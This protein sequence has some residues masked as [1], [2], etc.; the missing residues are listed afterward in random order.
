MNS[1]EVAARLRR[2]QGPGGRYFLL[3]MDHGLPAGPL[4]G[5]EDPVGLV[6]RI[7]GAPVTA[8]IAN[9][10][11]VSRLAPYLDPSRGLI[12]HL[13]GGT[14]LGPRPSSKIVSASVEAALALGADSVSVQIHFGDPEEARMLFDAGRIVDEATACGLPV[15]AMAYPPS[16][17]GG[18]SEDVSAAR[19]AARAAAELG[20]SVVQT[21]YMGGSLS[22]VVRSCPAPVVVS[23]GPRVATEEGWLEDIRQAIATGAAGVSAGR[24]LFQQSDPAAFAARIGD[25][26]FR[27]SDRADRGGG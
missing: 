16:A 24:N 4:P 12:V 13:S 18:R 9:P 17:L 3:A 8:L 11:I 26:V 20:A 27:P 15:L 5:L 19:H 2:L 7:R 6:R 23:G 10:G 1:V 14:V 22:D 21:T 25:V